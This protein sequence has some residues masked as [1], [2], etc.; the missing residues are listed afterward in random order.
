MRAKG[1]AILARE[2]QI[3]HCRLFVD[4]P[5]K[6][7]P[8]EGMRLVKANTARV[9]LREIEIFSKNQNLCTRGYFVPTAGNVSS[10]TIEQRVSFASLETANLSSRR[11]GWQSRLPCERATTRRHNSSRLRSKIACNRAASS[12][13]GVKYRRQVLLPRR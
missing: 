12:A 13:S 3:A 6:R 9:L 8:A 1:I 5:P 4:C 10:A 11:Q 7:A 2:C